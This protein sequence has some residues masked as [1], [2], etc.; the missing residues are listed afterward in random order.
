M[1]GL[2]LLAQWPTP[3]TCA[4]V[5]VCRGAAD[6][7]K[8]LPALPIPAVE[9]SCA[10]LLETVRLLLTA[11]SGLMSFGRRRR[12]CVRSRRGIDVTKT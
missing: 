6:T 2:K 3:L 1:K 12:T 11:E 9:H 4:R 5:V 8:R 7:K 10:R